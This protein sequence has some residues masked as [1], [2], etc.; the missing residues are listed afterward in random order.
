MSNQI[1]GILAGIGL[2]LMFFS[3]VNGVIGILA[4]VP[5]LIGVY[6]ISKNLNEVSI[7]KSFLIVYFGFCV[8]GVLTFFLGLRSILELYYIEIIS[9]YLILF[10]ISIS[11]FIYSVIVQVR[12]YR[13]LAKLTNIKA[14]DIASSLIKWGAILAV[15]LVGFIIVVVGYIFA[16][17][18]FFSL[19]EQQTTP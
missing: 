5:F 7:F 3:A 1:A 4:F 13:L 10:V 18:G 12:N 19:K 17:V 8:I 11:W 16:I 2:I 14:F 9:K 15:L 6:H